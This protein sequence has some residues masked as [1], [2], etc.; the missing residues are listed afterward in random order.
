MAHKGERIERGRS[1]ILSVSAINIRTFPRSVLIDFVIVEITNTKPTKAS[2]CNRIAVRDE[3]SLKISQK[4]DHNTVI[5]YQ[6]NFK[7]IVNA[8][9]KNGWYDHEYSA[10]NVFKA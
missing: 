5:K 3:L 8:C 7:K 2:I 10:S 1:L 9:I 6:S 4:G